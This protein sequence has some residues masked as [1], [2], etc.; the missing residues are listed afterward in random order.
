MS[1]SNILSVNFDHRYFGGSVLTTIYFFN[2][3]GGGMNSKHDHF[4]VAQRKNFFGGPG[5]FKLS[6]LH[7]SI[8]KI[9]FGGFELSAPSSHRYGS[10]WRTGGGLRSVDVDRGERDVTSTGVTATCDLRGALSLGLD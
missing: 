2:I 7:G 1:K 5:V 8:R 6:L 3:S 4:D 9:G 10:V